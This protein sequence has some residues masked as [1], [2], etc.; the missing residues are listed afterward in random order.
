MSE[1]ASDAIARELRRMVI[2]G[3]L[4]AGSIVS[5]AHLSDLLGCSRTPLRD[6]LQQLSHQYLIEVP[7]RRGILIPRLS[8]VDYQQLCEAQLLVG[9]ELT[10]LAAGRI[11]D[12]QLDGLRDV[13]A[14]QERSNDE[15]DSYSLA[16]LDGEYHGLIA[17]ATGN[18]YFTDFTTLLHSTLARFL[19]RAYESVGSADR[20]IA[21][22]RQIIETLENGDGEL[23]KA[24]VRE[25]VI[26]A[27]QR[28]LQILGLGD[29]S[30]GL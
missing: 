30:E 11:N 27:R 2:T 29:Q 10:Q 1:R 24:R 12:Q 15:R 13:V 9:S 3:E 25:H 7:P 6:A 20:S 17:E 28:V 19:Y 21:E 5:E 4:Q 16:E 18:Q 8:I 26:Q 22:H 14:R 23:A